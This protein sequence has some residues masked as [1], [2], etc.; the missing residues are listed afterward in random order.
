MYHITLSLFSP[1]FLLPLSSLSLFI[2]LFLFLSVQIDLWQ[3]GI[4]SE[5]Q[6]L[7]CSYIR[8][9]S[10]RT[11]TEKGVWWLSH[12]ERTNFFDSIDTLP[13]DREWLKINFRWR[14][15]TSKNYC[16]G[17][18]R[19]TRSKLESHIFIHIHIRLCVN[20]HIMEQYKNSNCIHL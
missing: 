2:L 17:D 1:R 5:C 19:D 12:R 3:S 4:I 11:K 7:C 20:H 9:A 10:F 16:Y 14:N 15:Y 18:R 8:Y 13:S 6:R